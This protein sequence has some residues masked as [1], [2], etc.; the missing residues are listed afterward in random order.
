MTSKKFDAHDD[1]DVSREVLDNGFGRESTRGVPE[2]VRPAGW[3]FRN[4]VKIARKDA[5][6][7]GTLPWQAGL[8]R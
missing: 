2:L 7:T 4:W 1:F 8:G 3:E 5:C 6:N